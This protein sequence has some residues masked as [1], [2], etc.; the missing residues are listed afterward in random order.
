M[1]FGGT[2]Q[3]AIMSCSYQLASLIQVKFNMQRLFS[4][5]L[6][7]GVLALSAAAQTGFNIDNLLAVKRVGDPQLSPDGRTVAYTVGTVDKA[8]NR[9]VTQIYTVNIDGTGTK[10]ITSG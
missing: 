8:A 7:A 5:I 9:V 1:L 2:K 4:S 3:C 10:Q 6:L